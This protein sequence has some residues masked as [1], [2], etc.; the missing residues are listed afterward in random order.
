MTCPLFS[1]LIQMKMHGTDYETLKKYVPAAILPSEWGGE[2]GPCDNTAWKEEF[3][4]IDHEF[5]PIEDGVSG[6]KKKKK[7]FLKRATKG[8]VKRIARLTGGGKKSDHKTKDSASSKAEKAENQVENSEQDSS[9]KT[10]T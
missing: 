2:A 7:R 10:V 9:P 4:A 1:S 5:S 6:K 3:L 8:T